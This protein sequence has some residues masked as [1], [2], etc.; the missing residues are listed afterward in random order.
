MTINK[1]VSLIFFKYIKP[2]LKDIDNPELIQKWKQNL[3]AADYE[4][5]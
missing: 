4:K 5:S 2:L 3:D 1:I